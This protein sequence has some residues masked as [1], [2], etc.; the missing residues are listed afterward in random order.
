MPLIGIVERCL[1]FDPAKMPTPQRLLDLVRKYMTQPVADGSDELRIRLDDKYSVS[2]RYRM[3][4]SL[5][6]SD[7]GIENF[8]DV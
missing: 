8:F 1:R 5:S 4:M 2:K 3:M 6:G 7:L